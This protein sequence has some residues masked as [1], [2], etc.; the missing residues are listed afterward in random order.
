MEPIPAMVAT[1]TLQTSKP[2]ERQKGEEFIPNPSPAIDVIRRKEPNI[3][4][5]PTLS[6]IF[7]VRIAI[8]ISTR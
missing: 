8:L 2:M 6:M 3:T 7:N 5:V 1:G 4:P